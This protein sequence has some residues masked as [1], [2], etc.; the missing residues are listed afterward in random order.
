MLHSLLAQAA[1]SGVEPTD[2]L[3]LTAAKALVETVAG[4][5]AEQFAEAVIHGVDPDPAIPPVP[6]RS[7]RAG[8]VRRRAVEVP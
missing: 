5:L 7:L 8:A 6:E 4:E 2:E 3:V 1:R